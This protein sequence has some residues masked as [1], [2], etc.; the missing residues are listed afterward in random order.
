M[1]PCWS[2]TFILNELVNH[3]DNGVELTIFSLKK[4]NEKMVHSEAYPFI[5]RTKY[6]LNPLNPYLWLL[7]VL[8]A[9]RKPQLYFMVL[10][11]LLKLNTSSLKLKVKAL[12]IFFL[13]PLFIRQTERYNLE[14]LH[15]HFSSYPAIM[16]WIISMFCKVPFSVTAHAHDIYVNQDLLPIIYNQATHIFTISQFNKNFI[17]NKLGTRYE[18]KIRVIHCGINLERFSFVENRPELVENNLINILSI[19]RLTGIKG[20]S[21]LLKALK[22]L[23]DDNIDFHCRIIGDGPL[24]SELNQLAEQLGISRYISFLGSK[25]TEEIPGYLK[26]ADV[27]ILACAQDKLEGHD[28]IPIVFME[29]MACGVPVIGTSISG[30][31]ELIRDRETGFCANPED[32]VSIK[33]NLLYYANHQTEVEKMR[34]A[35]RKLIENEF[36]INIVCKQ[37]RDAYQSL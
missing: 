17:L 16:A 6:P 21:Y 23:H 37:L 14:H 32:P 7:N 33:D 22:L 19:G 12:I 2:E 30:I 34:F 18:N 28:G 35:A 36:N 24:K 13:S 20:F 11:A 31:P 3:S 15:A 8:L 5:S 9:I 29:A 27:F 1:F 25:K 26:S 4:F 10:L